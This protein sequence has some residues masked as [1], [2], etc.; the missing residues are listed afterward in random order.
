MRSR[1]FRERLLVALYKFAS[2]GNLA[3]YLV[4]HEIA[5]RFGLDRQLGQLRLTVS[6]LENYGYIKASRTLGGGDEGGLNLMLTS[7]G[8]EAAEELLDEHPEYGLPYQAEVPAA[9]RYVRLDD[10]Q[11]TTVEESLSDLRLAVRSSNE[12]DEEDRLI[13]LS[14]IAAFEAVLIQPRVSTELVE[15]FVNRIIK[16]M[17]SIFGTAM[18]GAVADALIAKLLPFLTG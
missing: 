18:I 10:N 16:W 3:R 4:P 14:E 5:D 17:I 15:R 7:S 9:N 11:R 8:I 6:A 1:E 2:Q 12:T 13:A